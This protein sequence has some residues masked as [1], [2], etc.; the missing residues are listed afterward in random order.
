MRTPTDDQGR[1]PRASRIPA[2]PQSGPPDREASGVWTLIR[3]MLANCT[4]RQEMALNHLV[5][6]ALLSVSSDPLRKFTISWPRANRGA[7]VT[8]TIHK[9]SRIPHLLRLAKH[10]DSFGHNQMWGGS[11]DPRRAPWLGCR[12]GG[13]TRTRAPAPPS[14]CHCISRASIVYLSGHL[15]EAAG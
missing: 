9:R 6:K 12:T 10:G 1:R 2:Q 14:D 8:R 7:K 13:P 15:W 5:C 3:V 11:P 4:E